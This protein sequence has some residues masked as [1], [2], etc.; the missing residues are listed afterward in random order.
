MRVKE[1][2]Y[3]NLERVKAAFP[4]TELIRVTDAVAWLGGITAR[5]F[6]ENKETRCKKIGGK[7]FISSVALAR[8][9]S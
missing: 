3:D 6:Y 1:D 4:N 7:W 8:W 5:A 9:L 2:Y